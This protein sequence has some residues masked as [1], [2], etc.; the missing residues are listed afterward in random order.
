MPSN[1]CPVCGSV[2]APYPAFAPFCSIICTKFAVNTSKSKADFDAKYIKNLITI[3]DFTWCP[4][5]DES[6]SKWSGFLNL[7]YPCKHKFVRYI[8]SV[9]YPDKPDIEYVCSHCGLKINSLDTFRLE[10]NT[11]VCSTCN[12]KINTKDLS[13]LFP[14]NKVEMIWKP[15]LGAYQVCFPFDKTMLEFLKAKIPSGFR[16]PDYDDNGKFRSWLIDKDYAEA[17]LD[18]LKIKFRHC[19]F[20][21]I[22]KEKVD[23]YSQGALL[24]VQ[25]DPNISLRT[26]AKL[27]QDAGV[28]NS[29][30]PKWT[31]LTILEATKMYRKAAMYYHPDRN[32]QLAAEMSNLNKAWTELKGAY[33]K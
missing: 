14:M 5:C 26:F 23:E 25:F 9:Y 17:L 8:L 15:D 16:T 24:T 18:V 28:T 3:A 27:L 12:F 2:S 4:Y 6:P 10:E 30:E 7:K 33:W 21:V 29:I 1:I 19:T 11:H 32:P 22:T 31:E 20:T 13:E